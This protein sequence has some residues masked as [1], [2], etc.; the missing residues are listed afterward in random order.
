[1]LRED[2]GN[3]AAIVANPSSL[4][5]QVARNSLL[6]GALKA[7]G[8]N[9]DAPLP[10]KLFEVGDVVVL[11]PEADVGARN[12]RRLLVLYSNVQSG[13]E[14]VQGVLDRVMQV[15]GIAK[16]DGS[17]FGYQLHE[18]NEPTYFPGRQAHVM[19]NGKKIGVFGIVHP[20]VCAKFD[21]VS[22]TSVL[23]LELEPLMASV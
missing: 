14:V 5:V 3:S 7:L 23:E 16:F 18:S 20:D 15:V 4:D 1:V 11:D 10:A 17:D 6:P 9:K 13:F 22:P 21:I 19:R 12:S 2:D 8:A